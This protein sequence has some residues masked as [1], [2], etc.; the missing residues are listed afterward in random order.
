MA[1]KKT[2]DK[3]IDLTGARIVD[4]SLS[5]LATPQ[6]LLDGSD[7]AG[8]G[9]V[10][11]DIDPV[12]AIHRYADW[13]WTT[14]GESFESGIAFEDETYIVIGLAHKTKDGEK[15]IARRQK[16]SVVYNKNDGTF[17]I[18]NKSK[19]PAA[20]PAAQYFKNMIENKVMFYDHHAVRPKVT[21]FL[22]KSI[23]AIPLFPGKATSYIVPECQID[24]VINLIEGFAKQALRN[25]RL[26]LIKA[27]LE[28]G[29]TG[30]DLVGKVSDS[31]ATN[32]QNI[33]EEVAN[34][35]QKDKGLRPSTISK[36]M[37][38]LHELEARAGMYE[39]ALNCKMSDLKKDI[40][41]AK[42]EV[43]ELLNKIAEERNN[44]KSEAA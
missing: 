36:R 23:G 30:E 31:L 27:Q 43:D 3:K 17:T 32:L 11:K 40:Q 41:K 29:R 39:G 9:F 28:D 34:W 16:A 12:K 6:Q 44:A 33:A 22:I 35:S 10:F 25:S 1:D 2:T 15:K 8:L 14:G 7:K 5:G 26:T 24:E 18:V 42:L 20:A 13:V 37:A 38:A 19:L 21:S 4:F